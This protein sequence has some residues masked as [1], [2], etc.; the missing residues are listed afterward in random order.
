ML[1]VLKMNLKAFTRKEN[2]ILA[3][4]NQTLTQ[5]EPSMPKQG[6]RSVLQR[7]AAPLFSHVPLYLVG[8]IFLSAGMG[9]PFRVK[10]L[11]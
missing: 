7:A 8:V 10:A 6:G 5:I 4:K 11:R 3:D 9:F 1:N 2:P